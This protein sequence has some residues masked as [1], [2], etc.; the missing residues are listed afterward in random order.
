MG[1]RTTATRREH[2]RRAGRAVN[3]VVRE[4]YRPRLD[5]ATVKTAANGH[6]PSIF[7]ALAPSLAPALAHLPRHVSCP[8]HGGKDG[9]RLFADVA[10]S[11]GGICNTCGTFADGFALL[12]WV[13]RWT[14]RETLAAVASFLG[15]APDASGAPRRPLPAA[16]PAR[17]P[18]V[19]DEAKA[20]ALRRAWG[21]ALTIQAGDP[22]ALYLARRFLN[23]APTWPECLRH[24]P[25]M[26]YHEGPQ[27]FGPF[28]VMLA[29]IDGPDG[30]PVGLHRTYLTTDGHKAPVVAPKK[31][32]PAATPGATRG[33]AVRLFP[34]A[35]RL[36]VAEG[37]ETALAIHKLTGL[38]VWAALSAGA[39]ERL[40]LPA[41]V[42]EV[43]VCGDADRNGVGQQA[44]RRL[45]ARMVNEGRKVRVAVPPEP[46]P[47]AK[48][49]DWAD[50]WALEAE[51]GRGEVA[52]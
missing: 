51:H 2:T 52:P 18:P 47:G 1:P 37:V 5:A 33:G 45:A 24:H 27:A 11:G 22:V 23:L 28:P 39:L 3:H 8:G 16:A 43:I 32:M 40:E 36:A 6:W 30:R 13:N 49:R 50:V 10:E 7:G 4:V 21:E 17:V 26:L 48:G 34:V 41:E 25:G 38:S 44:A 31:T 9:L 35:D 15:L 19:P 29:R 42:R 12:M 14:F 46:D 20:A